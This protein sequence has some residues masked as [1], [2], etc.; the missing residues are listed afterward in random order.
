MSNEELVKLFQE[1]HD[2]QGC[3]E[4]LYFQNM[5]L[6]RKICMKY[7]GG[8]DPEDLAQECYFAVETAARLYD[9]TAGSFSTYL[10]IWLRQKIVSYRK[11]NGNS[12]RVPSYQR[13]KIREY[14]KLVNAWRVDM[15]R[16]PTEDELCDALQLSGQQVRD[17]KRDALALSVGSLDASI[18]E[19]GTTVGE[20][21][22]DPADAEAQAVES[23]FNGEL[24][25][26]LEQCI[27]ELDDGEAATI[28]ARYFEDRT[29]AEI[30]DRAGK[31]V[32]WA[33]VLERKALR[34]LRKKRALA[35]YAVLY[36][37]AVGGGLGAF[38]RTGVS[39]TERAAFRRLLLEKEADNLERFITEL[40]AL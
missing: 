2:P 32:Q 18:D 23:V 19:N 38:Q 12:I 39:S 11:T 27:D 14:N 31:S 33:S 30:A 13:D 1:G 24:R 3:L 15:G 25:E 8:E 9:P 10:C 6:I 26:A 4:K 36:G 17:L 16:D 28:R 21:V 5:G 34:K 20:M 22:P 37:I 40:R 29:Q 7:G 35:D